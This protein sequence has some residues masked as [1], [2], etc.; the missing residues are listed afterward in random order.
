MEKKDVIV[1]V[2]DMRGSGSLVDVCKQTANGKRV[3]DIV[4]KESR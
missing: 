4:V 3:I 2:N 1:N